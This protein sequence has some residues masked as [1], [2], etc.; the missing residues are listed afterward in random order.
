AMRA[1]VAHAA[2]L[3]P[4][5]VTSVDAARA[6]LEAAVPA[7]VPPS[8]PAAKAL[9]L[10]ALLILAVNAL[11]GDLSYVWFLAET[12]DHSEDLPSLP[13]DALL[14]YLSGAKQDHSDC[15]LAYAKRLI[16]GDPVPKDDYAALGWMTAALRSAEA[17]K[18][19]TETA[20]AMATLIMTSPEIDAE[21]VDICNILIRAREKAGFGGF[22]LGLTAL[23]EIW[24][25]MA[26]KGDA[27]GMYEL[28]SAFA[29]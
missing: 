12:L 8:V 19:E 22:D 13:N 7:A 9:K 17:H 2:S 1:V 18:Q 27:D 10:A 28:G 4:A 26:L 23:A 11:S 20:V 15:Q 25:D 16:K 14:W 21:L 24:Q 3:G 6:V 5:D 29:L